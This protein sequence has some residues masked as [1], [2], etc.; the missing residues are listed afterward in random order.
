MLGKHSPVENLDARLRSNGKD[1]AAGR[2]TR[3]ICDT[4][5]V[6]SPMKLYGET[7]NQ[8][9]ESFY[10]GELKKEHMQEAIDSW[11]EEL[12]HLDGMPAW[13]DGTYNQAML[14]ILKGKD[15]VAWIQNLRSALVAED[16]PLATV[17]MLIQLMLLTLNHM[18]RQTE[19]PV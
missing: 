1:T 16:L 18:R 5:G 15:A 4:A 11:C 3:R 17:S 7:F 12:R 19:E 8:A 9:A 14:S 2:L 6:S 10:R 13:R